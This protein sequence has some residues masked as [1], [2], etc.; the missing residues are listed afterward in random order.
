[1]S[2]LCTLRSPNAHERGPGADAS[3]R[4]GVERYRAEADVA[5]PMRMPPPDATPIATSGRCPVSLEIRLSA[6]AETARVYRDKAVIT[7]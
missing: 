4:I 5:I 3:D 7:A 2:E 1:M 6:A